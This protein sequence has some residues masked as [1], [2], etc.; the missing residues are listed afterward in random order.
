MTF[1]Q[2]LVRKVSLN[3]IHTLSFGVHTINHLRYFT[4]GFCEDYLHRPHLTLLGVFGRY[5]ANASGTVYL[6][7]YHAVGADGSELNAFLHFEGLHIDHLIN[8]LQ[9]ESEF[10]FL[11]GVFVSLLVIVHE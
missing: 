10:N 3:V 5:V 9:G 2:H 6:Q 7:C 8:H 11:R 4:V 1:L